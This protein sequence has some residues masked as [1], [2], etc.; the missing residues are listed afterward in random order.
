MKKKLTICFAFLFLFTA[1]TVSADDIGIELNSDYVY[2]DVSPFIIE[3]RTLVPLRAISEGMGYDVYWNGEEQSVTINNNATSAFIKLYIGS[4]N[5]DT[6]YGTMEIS[7][8]PR[9]YENKTM[10]PIRVISEVLGCEVYWDDTNR[11]VLITTVGTPYTY[12]EDSPYD[13]TVSGAS[14]FAVL[15]DE[16]I[17]LRDA[18]SSDANVIS[19]IPLFDTMTFIS[20]MGNGFYYVCYY[21]QYGYINGYYTSEFEPQVYEGRAQVVNC[22]T[23]ITMRTAANTSAREIMQV[24]LGAVVV[25]NIGKHN[26]FRLVSYGGRKGWV[27]ESYLIDIQQ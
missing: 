6:S 27:L 2:C 13:I 25:K 11:D 22:N 10:V 14:I 17:S 7:V 21:G 23:S 20:D 16:C 3:G 5:V 4:C 15:C 9:I 12:I 26:G 1:I 19:E 18:P 24:P 8:A